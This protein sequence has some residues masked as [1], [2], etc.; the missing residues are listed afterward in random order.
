MIAV[1]HGER[2]MPRQPLTTL[3]TCLP[4]LSVASSQR[5]GRGERAQ[6]D[7]ANGVLRD[8]SHWQRKGGEGRRQAPPRGRHL[9]YPAVEFSAIH[10]GSFS[11]FHRPFFCHWSTSPCPLTHRFVNK[12]SCFKTEHPME[13]GKERAGACSLEKPGS[14]KNS[15]VL[16]I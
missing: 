9:R 10:P 2:C 12:S 3:S 1:L 16:S 13:A 7:R 6:L 5:D 14:A 4:Y 15:M 8:W 11:H